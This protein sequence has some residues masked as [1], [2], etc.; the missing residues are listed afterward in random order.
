MS[1]LLY[2]FAIEPLAE[3]IR[4]STLQGIQVEGMVRRLL[5]TLFA[6]DTLVYLREDDDFKTLEKLLQ[7]FC[8]A[9]TAKFNLNKTE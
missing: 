7:R 9:S 6:D 8:L 1:C 2:N 5:V 4:K 3:S